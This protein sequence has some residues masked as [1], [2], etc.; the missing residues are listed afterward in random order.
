MVIQ[1]KIVDDFINT[2][3]VATICWAHRRLPRC[4]NCFYAYIRQENLLVFKSSKQ[5]LHS[6]LLKVGTPIAGT[7]YETEES[8]YNNRGI[9][10]T[11][12]ITG[13]EYRQAPEIYYKRYPTARLLPGQLFIAQLISLKYTKT[14]NGIRK[15]Y[16]W[17]I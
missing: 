11:G 12:E 1:K 14:F 16:L 17:S 7:I 9:Q 13:A 4:F 10:F 5:S 15:K 6:M 2:K 3:S 8:I